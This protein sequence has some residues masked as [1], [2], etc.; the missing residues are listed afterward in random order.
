MSSNFSCGI[1]PSPPGL[2]V[3]FGF[4]NSRPSALIERKQLHGCLI[5]ELQR[6]WSRRLLQVF[7]FIWKL[8]K[9]TPNISWIILPEKSSQDQQ[10][11][12]MLV[13]KS[14]VKAGSI[15]RDARGTDSGPHQEGKSGVTTFHWKT[16][17]PFVHPSGKQ[18]QWFISSWAS[19][20]TDQPAIRVI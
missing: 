7:F 5:V 13:P 20:Q 11:Y 9:N 1:F 8:N 14:T 2:G 15:C 10:R 19:Y 16:E 3:G 12:S 18:S 6:I 4:L 17:E